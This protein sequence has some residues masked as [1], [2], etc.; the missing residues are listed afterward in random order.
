MLA[1]VWKGWTK[2]ENADAYE[3]LL[4]EVVYPGLREIDGYR[5]GYILGQD[6]KDETEFVTFNFFES[7][8]AVKAF[9]GWEYETP[10]FE[11][12]ARRLL[13]RVEPIA[14]HYDA[15]DIEY[16]ISHLSEPRTDL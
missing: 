7:L 14:R 4:R 9:A 6:G 8:E 5:G 11:P 1:R 2:A 10:V 15:R 13:S 12:E 3:K 16:V